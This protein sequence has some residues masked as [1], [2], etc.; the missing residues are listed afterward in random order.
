ML[1]QRFLNGEKN[2]M[3]RYSTWLVIK[4]MQI[5]IEVGYHFIATRITKF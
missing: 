5:K 1:Q 2:N 3:K 4:E